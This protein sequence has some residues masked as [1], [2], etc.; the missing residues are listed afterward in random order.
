MDIDHFSIENKALDVLDR[1][2]I[3]K[4][5]VNVAKIAENV[6]FSVK[7]I[8]M[9]KEYAGV[10]AFH[11]NAKKVIYVAVKDPPTRKMFSIAHELG[12]IFLGHKNYEV[13]FRIPKT[14]G[15]YPKNESEA[16]SFA[17]HLLIPTFMVRE[18]LDKY[19][20][21]KGDYVKMSNIFGVPVVAMKET[22]EYLPS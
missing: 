12:H 11:D 17:A 10:A 15:T 14:E 6:G 3:T 19:N 22:L 20:L 21:T 13:L 18:Y 8:E 16:N 2:N 9:P 5:V 7:E 4:P 1:N